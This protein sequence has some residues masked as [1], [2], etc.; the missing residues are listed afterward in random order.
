MAKEDSIM[1]LY[2]GN[3]KLRPTDKKNR[4]DYKFFLLK[5]GSLE[6]KL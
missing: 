6:V 4:G 2:K 1:N 3:T 5:L